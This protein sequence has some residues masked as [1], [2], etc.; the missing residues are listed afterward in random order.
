MLPIL[1]AELVR[2]LP[3][4][5]STSIIGW[6]EA[7]VAPAADEEA[8]AFAE[9]GSALRALLAG[10]AEAHVFQTYMSFCEVNVSFCLLV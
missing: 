2:C 5:T 1:R 4:A 7:M 10:R 3:T 9:P 8:D 6:L